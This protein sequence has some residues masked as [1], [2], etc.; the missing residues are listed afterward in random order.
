MNRKSD[1]SIQKWAPWMRRALELASLAEGNTSPNPL[2]GAVV[3]DAE[4]RLVGEGFHS[5]AGEPH[6]EVWALRQAGTKSKGGT[7]IV[8]LE[9][10]CHQ[11]R[12]PPCTTAIL[13][14]G[15][16]RVV[17]A[18]EDPDPRVSGFGASLL[19]E[20]G[21]EVITGVLEEE[22]FSQNR[23]FIFRITNGR[24]WGVLKWAMSLDGRV[25]LP[26][27]KSQWISCKEARDWVYRLRS[28]C[29]A[30][31]VG[32]GTLR[33]DDPL[34][35]SR[36]LSNP[37]PIRVVLTS[38]KEL[39][40]EAQLWDTSIARTIIAHGPE[41]VEGRIK[42]MKSAPEFVS[43]DSPGPLDL[44]KKLVLKGCNRV[45]WECG[46]SLATAAIEQGCVQE[47]AIVLA[48]KLLGGESSMTPLGDF[49][50]TS[51]SQVLDLVAGSTRKIGTDWLF[52]VPFH[53]D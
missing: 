8:T 9:P 46:P 49:G 27:G 43:L 47:L 17:I 25:A 35:T 20:A 11:G 45:L 23:A 19:K 26:N 52:S 18:L 33:A 2:V 42:Q 28:K 32:G 48:P 4:G 41:F 1:P 44:L 24:P 13:T 10:C 29:D 15:I 22:A 12:T 7:L 31:I 39:P 6:A 50:F 34:L 16:S 38:G 53:K 30:V 3:L 51:M 14:S 5:Q 21:L 40:L 37:E 36:G